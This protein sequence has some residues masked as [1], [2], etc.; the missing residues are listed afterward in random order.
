MLIGKV[1]FDLEN[2]GYL[3]GILNVTPDSFSDGGRFIQVEEAVARAVK[4][5]DEGAMIIDIGG[6][7]TRPGHACVTVEEEIRRVVPVI[8]ALM[9]RIKVPISIDTTKSEVARAALNAG[10]SMI[11]DVWGLKKDAKMA[12]VAVEYDV[13]VCLMHNRIEANY[14]DLITDMVSDLSESLQIALDSGIKKEKIILDPGIGFA[15]SLSDNLEVMKAL[16]VFKAMGYPLLLGTSR[17]SMI[18]Q[19]LDLPVSE[20]LEGTIATT[21]LGYIEGC[22]IFRVHDIRENL[23]ALKMIELMR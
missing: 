22:R 13:P 5:V 4:M 11:N 3:M 9:K 8:E 6:E 7:S 21:V 12:R 2:K 23:R 14:S 16:H 10:A 1:E 19:A 18:G 15:K 17:K 20:R